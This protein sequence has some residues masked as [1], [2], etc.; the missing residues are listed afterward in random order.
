MQNAL[1][2]LENK[3]ILKASI[4]HRVILAIVLGFNNETSF[5]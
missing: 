5:S 3:I 2:K 1:L 4:I